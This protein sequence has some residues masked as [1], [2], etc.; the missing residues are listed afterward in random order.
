MALRNLRSS[1]EYAELAGVIRAY[2]FGRRLFYAP[3]VSPI[4]DP[5]VGRVSAA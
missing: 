2:A 1:G 4:Y 5:S 3:G